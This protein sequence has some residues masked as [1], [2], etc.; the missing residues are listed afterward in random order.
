MKTLTAT[1]SGD[2]N[3]NGSVSLGVEHIVNASA[4]VLQSAASRKVHGGAGTFNLPLSL[5]PTAPTVEPRQGPAQTILF[6]FDK[7]ITSA[8]AAITEGT[9]TAG[10][11]TFSGNDVIV[12]LTGVSD[13]Q[14]VTVT[15]T[16][17]NA[18][19]TL[20]NVGSTDGA[21]GGSGSVRVGF[22]L[23]DVNQNRVVTV[24][25]L[26]QVNAQIAQVVTSANYLKDINA[27]GTLSVA[28]KGIANTRVTK[29]L[30]AL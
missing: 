24:S 20:T 27:S 29:A 3:F 23:G 17:V 8:T 22:L 11:P 10:T 12:G 1:Y 9:A 15:L 6:T 14:Y 18:T 28:D 7:P 25:D 16:N 13:Q 21:A 2:G 19:V 5:V 4:P 26:A 30:P